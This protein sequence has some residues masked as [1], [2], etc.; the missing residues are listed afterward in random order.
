MLITAVFP[1]W[2]RVYPAEMQRGIVRGLPWRG[3]LALTVVWVLLVAGGEGAYLANLAANGSER[4]CYPC[5]WDRARYEQI[6]RPVG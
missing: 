3:W 2:E 1:F 5:A 4:A 6:P